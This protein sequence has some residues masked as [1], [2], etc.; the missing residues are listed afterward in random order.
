[1]N[2]PSITFV[3]N[4]SRISLGYT[5]QTVGGRPKEDSSASPNKDTV[6]SRI[7]F[8]NNLTSQ[9][10]RLHLNCIKD[11]QEQRAERLAKN[12]EVRQKRMIKKLPKG[13]PSFLLNQYKY[14]DVRSEVDS[15]PVRSLYHVTM[16]D[17]GP[18]TI[19]ELPNKN[20]GGLTDTAY[21]TMP[22]EHKWVDR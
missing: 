1:M 6:H 16:R 17:G 2:S 12:L 20:G 4:Q 21:D 3:H 9:L 18:E 5:E 19:S 22:L 8:G 14:P 11:I 13:T 15:L 7:L 10:S